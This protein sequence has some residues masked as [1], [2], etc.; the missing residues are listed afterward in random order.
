MSLVIVSDFVLV[1][2]ESRFLGL[3]V[4]QPISRVGAQRVLDRGFEIECPIRFARPGRGCGAIGES[5]GRL[6]LTRGGARRVVPSDD[7]CELGERVIAL[8][9]DRGD[10]DFAQLPFEIV[11]IERLNRVF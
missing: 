1:L 9:R 4:G 3:V 8:P 6:R 7:P 10:S 11:E 5:S 2:L